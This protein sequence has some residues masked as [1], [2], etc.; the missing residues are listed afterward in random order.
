MSGKIVTVMEPV[1]LYDLDGLSLDEAVSYFQ[2]LREKYAD[3][4]AKISYDSM[5]EESDDFG[6][7]ITRPETEKERQSRE[8]H[9]QR[10]VD[11]ELRQ[12]EALKRKY[13]PKEK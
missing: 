6:V 12:Y 4:D 2:D 8:N 10:R 7:R 13:E 5:G 1:S 9:E 11:A 3:S